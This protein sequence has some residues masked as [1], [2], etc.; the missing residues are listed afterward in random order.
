MTD[1]W[2]NWLN[3]QQR[4]LVTK[5]QIMW[6]ANQFNNPPAEQLTGL[7]TDELTNWPKQQ[8]TEITDRLKSDQL[9]HRRNNQM[10]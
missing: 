10:V 6:W 1:R 3:D 4:D 5:V 2:N 7:N 9:T 8:Q